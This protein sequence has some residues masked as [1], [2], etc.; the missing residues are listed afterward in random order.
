MLKLCRSKMTGRVQSRD[1]RDAARHRSPQCDLEAT[2]RD[3]ETQLP[4]VDAR[5]RRWKAVT[6][7]TNW[8]RSTGRNS[9]SHSR[10]AARRCKSLRHPSSSWRVRLLSEILQTSCRGRSLTHSSTECETGKRSRTPHT[11]LKATEWGPNPVK[12]ISYLRTSPLCPVLQI[13]RQR[14]W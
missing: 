8:R 12:W 2:R 14:L 6:K 3:L 4:A 11:R 9:R 10:R 5:M 13:F 1:A 7:I